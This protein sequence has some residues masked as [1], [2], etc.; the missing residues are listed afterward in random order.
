MVAAGNTWMDDIMFQG[1]EKNG[2]GRSNLT[3]REQQERNE[4]P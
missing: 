1:G 3:L 2:S 4:R